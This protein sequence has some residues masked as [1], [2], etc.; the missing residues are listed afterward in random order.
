MSSST[1]GFQNKVNR[2]P[3]VA[4]EGDFAGAN[5]WANVLAGPGAVL[6]S[7]SPRFCN[8]GRFVWL[9]ELSGVAVGTF[10]N[11]ADAKL[12]FLRRDQLAPVQTFL[13]DAQMYVLPGQQITLYDQGSFW[14]RFAD[15]AAS[16][17]AV[18]ALSDGSGVYSDAAGSDTSTADFTGAIDAQGVLT[19]SAVTGQIGVGDYVLGASVPAGTAILAQLSGTAGG[20]GTYQTSHLGVVASSAMVTHNAVETNFTVVSDAGA[21]ELAQISTWG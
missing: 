16:G 13:A 20:A 18:Y 6:A 12:G 11:E 2:Q 4:V 21:G 17:N 15:G 14:A 19:A 9:L 8:V 1:S 5:P 10:R 3:A 7:G